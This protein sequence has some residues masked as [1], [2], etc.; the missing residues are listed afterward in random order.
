[1]DKL[2]NGKGEK[3]SREDI[4]KKVNEVFK[5]IFD[6]DNIVVSDATTAGDVDDWDSLTHITLI[7]T[8]EEAFNIKFEMAEIISF[9]NVGE[10]IDSIEKKLCK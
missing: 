3:M 7:A 6:D 8:V 1:M 2:L 5:D 9:K 10:M 4:L